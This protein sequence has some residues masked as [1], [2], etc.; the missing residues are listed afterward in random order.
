MNEQTF[1]RYFRYVISFILY[2]FGVLVV[3]GIAFFVFHEALSWPI[4]MAYVGGYFVG[5]LTRGIER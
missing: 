1:E 4:V 5:Q 2:L 3:Y